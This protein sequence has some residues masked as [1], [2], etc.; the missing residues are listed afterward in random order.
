[1]KND[2]LD[3]LLRIFYNSPDIDDETLIEWIIEVAKIWNRKN[4]DHNC[5]E[6]NSISDKVIEIDDDLQMLNDI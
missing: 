4:R 5:V 6:L 2:K 1:M 3:I